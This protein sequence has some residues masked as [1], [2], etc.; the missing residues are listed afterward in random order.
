MDLAAHHT[1]DAMDD[2]WH[3]APPL[4]TPRHGLAAEVVDDQ[5]YAIGGGCRYGLHTI[6]STTGTV[7][8]YRP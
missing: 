6:Y 3:D 2:R 5:I 8:V 7:Q 4:A 1:Y